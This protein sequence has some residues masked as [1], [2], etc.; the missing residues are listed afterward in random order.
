VPVTDAQVRG[1]G[2][3]ALCCAALLARRGL[4]ISLTR[5]VPRRGLPAL[6]LTMETASVLQHIFDGALALDFAR[7]VDWRRVD[8]QAEP[9][10]TAAPGLVV[11]EERLLA[12][13]RSALRA[14]H[15]ELAGSKA[16]ALLIQADGQR[17]GKRYQFGKRR[18]NWRVLSQPMPRENEV[19]MIAD[20][21]GWTFSVGCSQP[22]MTMEQR[23]ELQPLGLPCA[24]RLSWPFCGDGWFAC[25]PAAMTLDPVCG[26]G[27]GYAARSAVWLCG[28][29][30]SLPLDQAREEYSSRLVRA[31]RSHL[32]ECHQLY[33]TAR[34]AAT[35]KSELQATLRGLA[36]MDKLISQ[37]PP[38]RT[39]LEGLDIY[40][41]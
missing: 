39:R 14:Q 31:F 4:R 22:A 33:S 41:A 34:F 21:T 32:A 10:V 27:A 6:L 1:S 2:I 28:L 20:K 29:L 38:M 3:S 13:M 7:T 37:L 17:V 25:G 16:G 15:G 18:A 9:V 5:T 8:W 23:M 12:S 11:E 36:A 19:S 26:D 24:P 40:R 35:W 30:T